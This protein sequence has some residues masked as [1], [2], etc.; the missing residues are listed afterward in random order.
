M[1]CDKGGDC[2]DSAERVSSAINC[3]ESSY[4]AMLSTAIAPDLNTPQVLLLDAP[5][6]PP[7]LTSFDLKTPWTSHQFSGFFS[8]P[9]PSYRLPNVPANQTLP[10]L[11]SLSFALYV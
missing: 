3:C 8:F 9:S 11:T 1:G 7:T 2:N 4:Q 5:Q 10:H 6:P